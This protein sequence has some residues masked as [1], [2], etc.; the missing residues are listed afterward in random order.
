[1]H[2]FL[3]PLATRFR[4]RTRQ[5][6]HHSVQSLKTRLPPE[7]W[8]LVL[9]ELWD[10]SLLIAARVCSSFNDRCIA[11]YLRR[12]NVTREEIATGSLAISS[13]LLGVLQLL[14][15][16]PQIHTLVCRFWA[17]NVLRDLKYLREFLSRQ[18]GLKELSVFF[19][20]NVAAAY[21]TDTMFPYSQQTLLTELGNVFR[22]MTAKSMGPVVIMDS[23]IHTIGRW[24]LAGGLVQSQF[25]VRAVKSA[26]RLCRL[27]WGPQRNDI[28]ASISSIHCTSITS[29][30]SQPFT[31]ITLDQEFQWSMSLGAR[32]KAKAK[33]AV[34]PSQLER[35][36]PHI[37]FPILRSLQINEMVDPTIL[38]PFLIRHPMIERIW[39]N[40]DHLELPCRKPLHQPLELPKLT[41]LSCRNPAFLC[42][43]LDAFGWSPRLQNVS[44][45]LRR[46]S[47]AHVAALKLG[48]RRLSLTPTSI[49]LKVDVWHIDEGPWEPIGDDEGRIVGCLYHVSS[50]F[51]DAWSILDVRRLI[52]WLAMLPCLRRVELS[53]FNEDTLANGTVGSYGPSVTSQIRAALPWVAH[54]SMS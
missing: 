41:D 45:A 43:A 31:L 19:Y 20:E 15:L 54:V 50:V 12:R 46:H 34:S 33:N 10:D 35:I 8:E 36:I 53:I 6:T 30:T 13:D 44:I 22:A 2:R 37:T 28:L 3:P 51:I 49:T 16:T 32:W 48:L 52:P 39:F 27:V 24:G 42:I 9:E 17:F 25:T 5:R 38:S 47:P 40:P 11:I 18:H 23:T 4:T 26:P 1:M 14:R 29:R 21:E 7:L